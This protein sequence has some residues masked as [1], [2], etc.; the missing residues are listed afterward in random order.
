[1]FV[2]NHN[3]VQNVFVWLRATV[4]VLRGWMFPSYNCCVKRTNNNH[5]DM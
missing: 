1:M 5:N 2:K 4:T 3:D